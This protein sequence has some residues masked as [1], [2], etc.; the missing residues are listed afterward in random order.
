MLAP[1]IDN[2]SEY[3]FVLQNFWNNADGGGGQEHSDLSTLGSLLHLTT[4]G[5][6]A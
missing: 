5:G 6:A 4:S 1:F 3:G 2:L